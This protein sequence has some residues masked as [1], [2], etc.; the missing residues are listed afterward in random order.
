M[1]DNDGTAD[2]RMAGTTRLT[3][4][5]DVD[6]DIDSLTFN[7]TAGAFSISGDPGVSLGIG[8]GGITNNDAQLQLLLLPIALNASQTWNAAAGPLSI[9]NTVAGHPLITRTLTLDGAN[10]IQIAGA[11]TQAAALNKTGAGTLTFNGLNTNTYTGTTTVSAGTLALGRT[12]GPNRAIPGNL[13]I[14][15]GAGGAGAD[16]VRLDAADQITEA[17]GRTVTVNNSGLLNLNGF[18]ETLANL[19]INGGSV[20]GAGSLIVNEALTFTGGGSISTAMLSAPASPA[21]VNSGMLNISS[22]G[23]H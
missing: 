3:P 2:I 19:A 13:V 10:N 16:V 7:N 17:A 4:R 12:G 6:W 9:G 15:D 18:N 8:A 1:P 20:S 11:I 5:V 14:G 22:G 21:V 23:Q